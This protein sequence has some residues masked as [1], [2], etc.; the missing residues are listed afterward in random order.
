MTQRM[1]MRDASPAS[2]GAT[3]LSPI[4]ADSS[5]FDDK[6]ILF[7]LFDSPTQS[8]TGEKSIGWLIIIIIRLI[9]LAATNS[10]PLID[11]ATQVNTDTTLALLDPISRKTGKLN[12]VVDKRFCAFFYVSQITTEKVMFPRY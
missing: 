2:T 12:C 11:L 5:T 10:Q 1:L 3:A 9:L 4:Q 6:I 7:Q 8:D